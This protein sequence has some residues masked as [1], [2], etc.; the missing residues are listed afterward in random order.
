MNDGFNP[1]VLNQRDLER[2][3]GYKELLDFYHGHQWP[4]Y[5]GRGPIS[6]SGLT[7]TSIMLLL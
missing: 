3:K 6:A 5:R 1:T 2:L 7:L 4:G